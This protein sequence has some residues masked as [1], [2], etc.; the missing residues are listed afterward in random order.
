MR[1]FKFIYSLF[2]LG[3]LFALHLAKYIFT[4]KLSSREFIERFRQ[5]NIGIISGEEV[6]IIQNSADCICCNVCSVYTSKESFADGSEIC[7]RLV[8]DSTQYIKADKRNKNSGYGDCPYQ[9][10]IGRISGFVS[11]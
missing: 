10:D 5:D 6:R 1:F 8:R 4:K 9:I 11:K 3:I 2:F 7:S